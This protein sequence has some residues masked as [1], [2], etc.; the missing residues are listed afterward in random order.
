MNNMKTI[1]PSCFSF[2]YASLLAVALAASTFS[3]AQ[4]SLQPLHYP[5]YEVKLK[6]LNGDK[7]EGYLKKVTDS[8]VVYTYDKTPV[9][10][11]AHAYD[12]VI[13]YHNLA[14]VSLRRKG[15]V[16]R[17]ALIGAVVGAGVGAIGGFAS[18]DDP[19]GELFSYSAGDK[20]GFLA[21]LA[22]VPGALV[23]AIVG[24]SSQKFPVDGRKDGLKSLQ[25]MIHEKVHGKASPVL[26]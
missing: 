25:Q 22:V 12:K 20:A 23:G 18:G 13:G 8:T 19:P 6:L 16:G 24:S 10:A 7:E 9:G 21:I 11:P 26:E 5:T 15:A 2:L 4:D 17:G 14:M 1:I 3:L